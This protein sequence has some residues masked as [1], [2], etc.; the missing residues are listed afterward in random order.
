MFHPWVTN[1]V[2]THLK[3]QT[4]QTISKDVADKFQIPKAISACKRNGE[5]QCSVEIVLQCKKKNKI[6]QKCMD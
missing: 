4:K 3:Q 6:D 1:A 5:I 2:K